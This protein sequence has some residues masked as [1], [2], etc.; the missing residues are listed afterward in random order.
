MNLMTM[1]QVKISI[2]KHNMMKVFKIML[3]S[4]AAFMIINLMAMI[5]YSIITQN[6]ILPTFWV[7]INVFMTLVFLLIPI[8][9]IMVIKR[10]NL[11]SELKT[12]INEI[13]E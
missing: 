8:I 9:V 7:G 3:L 11:I 10:K 6:G 1:I 13:T 5:V 2:K 12:I 4:Y